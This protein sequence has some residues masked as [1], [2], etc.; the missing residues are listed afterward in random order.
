MDAVYKVAFILHG[1]GIL[2]IIVGYFIELSRGTRGIH[3]AMLHGASLQV[4]TGLIM[5]DLRAMNYI[6]DEPELNYS[7]VFVKFAIS[8]GILALCVMGRKVDGDK[9]KWWAGVGV[10][11]LV[12]IFIAIR[13]NR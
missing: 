13:V 10:L 6:K 9:T 3:P 4:A 12:N 5:V 2:A 1:I 7:I 8:L 11:T